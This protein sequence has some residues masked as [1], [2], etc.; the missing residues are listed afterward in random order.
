MP[1]KDEQESESKDELTE[2]EEQRGG[3]TRKTDQE[4]NEEVEEDD[5]MEWDLRNT[6]S[7]FSELSELSRDCVESVDHGASVRGTGPFHSHPHLDSW[8][9]TT[10]INFATAALVLHHV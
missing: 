6:D 9:K 1:Q 5:G 4:D 8:I 3:E 7:V 2:V 10:D